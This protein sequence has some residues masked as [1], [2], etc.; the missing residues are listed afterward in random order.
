MH[1]VNAF[2]P[3]YQRLGDWPGWPTM[4]FTCQLARALVPEHFLTVLNNGL[5]SESGKG[6]API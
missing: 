2:L 4:Y 5:E 1:V 3:E 6:L